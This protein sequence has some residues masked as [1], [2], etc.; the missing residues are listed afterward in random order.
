[1]HT[2]TRRFNTIAVGLVVGLLTVFSACAGGSNESNGDEMKT[3]VLKIGVTVSEESAPGGIV[4]AFAELVA[5]NS[6]GRIVPEV[7]YNAVLGNDSELINKTQLG[8]QVQASQVSTSNLSAQLNT[9][10]V[11]DLPYIFDGA[12]ANEKIF[13]EGGS[14]AGPVTERIQEEALTRNL[15]VG[16]VA[17]INFRAAVMAKVL[18]R[19]PADME[20]LLIRTS[21]SAIEQASVS[22]FGGV[23]V[24]M[25]ISEVYT[26]LQTGAID[27]ETIPLWAVIAFGHT[28]AARAYSDINFQGFT[29]VLIFNQD[30]YSS[31][32]ADL[33]TVIDD[34]ANEV[35]LEVAPRLYG[36][37][38][39]SSLEEIQA[40]GG[41]WYELSDS[42]RAQFVELAKSVADEYIGSAR[43]PQDWYE[44][45]MSRLD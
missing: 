27:G 34:A 21:A 36:D 7:F 45:V 15:R 23:P 18:V 33:R 3:Y 9:F 35:A 41:E 24:A 30:W 16:W 42:E 2:H 20:G 11:F 37:I 39:Q 22:A 5:A 44:L 13:Y 32:P 17:P 4:A 25:G 43:V 40:A 26:A 14:F 38:F 31:L 8:G 19:S 29:E 28:D 1:M 10:N 12:D 6:E